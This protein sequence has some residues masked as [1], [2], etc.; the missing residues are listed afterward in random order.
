M[1]LKFKGDIMT[2]EEARLIASASLEVVMD[3]VL[4]IIQNDSH[5]W[6]IRPCPSCQTISGMWGKPFGC[7]KFKADREKK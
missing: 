3:A 4:G 6:S 5:T 2:E 1:E 7:C